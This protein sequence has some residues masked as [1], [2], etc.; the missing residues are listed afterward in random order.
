[1]CCYFISRLAEFGAWRV[2]IIAHGLFRTKEEFRGLIHNG[3]PPMIELLK[4]RDPN[5]Q[6]NI[7]TSLSKLA[8]FSGWKPC[9]IA[10]G[11]FLMIE[12]LR[13]LIRG[14]VS[15]LIGLLND[16]DPSVRSCVATLLSGL[17]EFGE[18]DRLLLLVAY[19]A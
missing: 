7:V 4:D 1:M 11:S 18:G 3:I 19:F 12:N 16:P 15:L 8:Q 17:A 6:S 5:I 10:H 9:I 14:S 13:G 2:C